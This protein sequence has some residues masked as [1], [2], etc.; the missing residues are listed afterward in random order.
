MHDFIHRDRHAGQIMYVYVYKQLCQYMC[1]Y[2]I[3]AQRH[4][5]CMSGWKQYNTDKT[6]A[7]CS[8]C[9]CEETHLNM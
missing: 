9:T 2:Y 7:L 4:S 8:V 6:Q 5:Y 1:V 3:D